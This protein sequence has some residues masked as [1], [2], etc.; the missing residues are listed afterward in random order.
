MFSDDLFFSLIHRAI[1]HPFLMRNIH[2]LHHRHKITV[3]LAATYAHPFEFIFGDVLAVSSGAL[4]L[5]PRIHYWTFVCFLTY[6]QS[7]TINGHSGYDFPWSPFSIL[8]LGTTAEYHDYHHSHSG[9][10]SGHFMIWDTLF[11]GNTKYFEKIKK[12]Y[13]KHH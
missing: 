5:G 10:Y 4:I 13:E 12:R 8:P 1:H 9:N 3:G 11:G 7:N 6:V 2:Y